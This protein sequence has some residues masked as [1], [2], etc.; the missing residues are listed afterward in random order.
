M[1][2][3]QTAIVKAERLLPDTQLRNTLL[4]KEYGIIF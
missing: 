2:S 3:T 4:Q 1:Y